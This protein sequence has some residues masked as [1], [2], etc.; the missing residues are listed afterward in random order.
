MDYSNNFSFG[1]ESDGICGY[2]KANQSGGC[3]MKSS[4]D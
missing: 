3:L 4:A 2:G 1:S